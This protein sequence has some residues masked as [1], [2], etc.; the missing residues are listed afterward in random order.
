MVKIQLDKER[1]FEL[2]LNAMVIFEE[3]T[4]K[5]LF[6]GALSQDMSAK[7]LRALL[8]AGLKHEDKSLTEEQVGGMITLDNMSRIAETLTKAWGLANG[9]DKSPLSVPGPSV[10]TTSTWTPTNIGV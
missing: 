6:K 2:D 10:S 5:S 7:E 4:G 8:Y 3:L 9:E 1:N